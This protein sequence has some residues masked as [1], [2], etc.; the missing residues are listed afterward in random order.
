MELPASD[1]VHLKEKH[2]NLQLRGFDISV[3]SETQVELKALPSVLKK[4]DPAELLSAMAKAFE[5]GS[6]DS[7]S[8]EVAHIE[9]ATIACH[10]AVRAGEFLMEDELRDLLS[11]AEGIDFFHN[12][13]HGRRVFKWFSSHQV[14]RWFDR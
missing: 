6:K 11:Q 9:F 13:P 7:A 10:S 1:V 2:E 12:C 14:E 3:M 5:E 8:E 4:R